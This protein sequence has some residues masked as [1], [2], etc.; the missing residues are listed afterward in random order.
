MGADFVKVYD[1]L[2]RDAYFAIV[3][4]SKRVIE[5]PLMILL[6]AEQ[7]IERVI[8]AIVFQP[9]QQFFMSHRVNC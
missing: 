8:D 6:E 3:Q 1:G 9:L 4:E 7:E 5:N 2:S